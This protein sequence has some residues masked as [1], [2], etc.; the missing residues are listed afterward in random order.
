[1]LFL[2]FM[3]YSSSFVSIP[4][5]N[6]VPEASLE[7]CQLKIKQLSPHILKFRTKHEDAQENPFILNCSVVPCSFLFIFHAGSRGLGSNNF[8][9]S[10]YK[11]KTTGSSHVSRLSFR[12]LWLCFCIQNL[13]KIF[14]YKMYMTFDKLL[15]TFCI[16]NLAGIVLLI[17]HTKHIQ[18][19][20]KMWYTF[21]IHFAYI[22]Y[23]SVVYI[24][25][26]FCIQNVY[27]VSVWQSS[28]SLNS[29]LC[30]TV[31]GPTLQE[32]HNE[33]VLVQH[34]KSIPQNKKK[35]KKK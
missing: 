13:Y 19:F 11:E 30:I 28:R 31:T 2:Q 10:S 5:K 25:C 8:W 22:F 3:L 16:Q 6:V 4:I 27:K 18:K 23:T 17:L 20:V 34:K 15:Y 35:L 7:L 9:N 32:Y 24:L 1:M 14:V 29:L 33:H 21:C 26:N 12:F